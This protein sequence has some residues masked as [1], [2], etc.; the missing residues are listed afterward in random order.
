MLANWSINRRFP[1][2]SKEFLLALLGPALFHTVGHIST[3]VSFSKVAVSFTHVIKSAEPVFSV[4]FSSFL[5]EIY[6]LKNFKEIDGLNLYGLISLVSF[7]YLLPVVI[8]VEGSQWVGGYKNA[9]VAVGGR[10]M[11]FYGMVLCSGIFYHLYN[12]SSYQTLDDISPLTFSVGNT[13]KRVVVIVATVLFFRNPVK[14]LNA[15][16]SAIAILGTFLYSQVTAKKGKKKEEEPAVG[17]EKSR[18]S[19]EDLQKLR[20]EKDG[21]I[22]K[23]KEEMEDA[24]EKHEEEL[25]KSR[26]EKDEVQ[27]QLTKK[28]DGVQQT[29]K[30]ASDDDLQK[31]RK[32]KVEEV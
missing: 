27:K 29:L 7:V 26:K 16:G 18:E 31:L 2:I 32:E 20:D 24:S 15:L 25:R 14:P 8:L 19:E 23:L 11:E 12:Q 22:R 17:D 1:K 3:C 30:R 5:G 21:E 4:I 28:N 6:P 13:M 10:S 9:I